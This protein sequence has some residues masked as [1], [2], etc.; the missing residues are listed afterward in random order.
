MPLPDRIDLGISEPALTTKI[1]LCYVSAQESTTAVTPVQCR[2]KDQKSWCS[3][4]RCAY[5]KA[6]VKCSVAYHGG[7]SDENCPKIATPRM[8][9]QKRLR[10]RKSDSQEESNNRPQLDTSISEGD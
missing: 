9:S 2:C 8:R 7:K 5:I 3:T 4:R 6:G 1:S 10:F